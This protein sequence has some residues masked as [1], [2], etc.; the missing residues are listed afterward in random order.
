MA[1]S[2]AMAAEWDAMLGDDACDDVG[3]APKETTRALFM[4]VM[5]EV[6]AL[7][8]FDDIAAYGERGCR[9]RRAIA[10]AHAGRRH[11]WRIYRS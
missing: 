9:Y 7:L 3:E 5:D 4:D 10:R 8:G 2:S 11:G 1:E 6:D